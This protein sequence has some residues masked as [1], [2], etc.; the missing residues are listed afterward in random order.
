MI[1]S[2]ALLFDRPSIS[3]AACILFDFKHLR[4][5]GHVD[6]GQRATSPPL[7]YSIVLLNRIRAKENEPR[8]C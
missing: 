1:T 2:P 8:W 3:K 5:H 4:G 6:L 7:T